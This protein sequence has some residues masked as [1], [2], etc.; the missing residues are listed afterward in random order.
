MLFRSELYPTTFIFDD[1]IP[2]KDFVR[3]TIDQIHTSERNSDFKARFEISDTLFLNTSISLEPHISGSLMTITLID[4]NINKN[5]L[6]IFSLSL[7]QLGIIYDSPSS[8]SAN[9]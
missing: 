5:I 7:R 2:I 4:H 8:A 3:I 9:P 6:K 1:F